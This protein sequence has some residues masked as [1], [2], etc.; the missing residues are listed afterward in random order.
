MSRMKSRALV[1]EGLKKH[2]PISGP[3]LAAKLGVEPGMVDWH[4][5]MLRESHFAYVHSYSQELRKKHMRLWAVGNKPDEPRR[6]E[7]DPDEDD[8]IT[9]MCDTRR[10]Q[11]LIA[12]IKPFRDP[13]LFLTAGRAA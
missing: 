10:R 1:F 7:A 12:R 8:A 2:G 9:I 11:E 13:M 5:K 4:L 6:F 3:D